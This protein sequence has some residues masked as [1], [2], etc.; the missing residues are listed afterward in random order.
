M[1]RKSTPIEEVL[2]FNAAYEKSGKTMAAFALQSNL[3]LHAAQWYR[4]RAKKHLSQPKRS[5][6]N[7]GFSLVHGPPKVSTGIELNVSGVKIALGY[8]FSVSTL[9][10]VL[11]VLGESA[12][13]IEVR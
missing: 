12:G 7:K 8:D 3:A 2:E 9:K 13:E 10:R 1:P 5:R 11:Y 6:A 4:S